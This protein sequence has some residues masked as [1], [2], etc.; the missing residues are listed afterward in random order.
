MILCYEYTVICAHQTY[1]SA[2]VFSS[3]L[4]CGKG[5]VFKK[6]LNRL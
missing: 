1:K 4:Q 6:P 2:Q 5:S 3:K